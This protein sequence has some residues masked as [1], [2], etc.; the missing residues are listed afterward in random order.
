MI[1][2]KKQRFVVFELVQSPDLSPAVEDIF[3]AKPDPGPS[4]EVDP[5]EFFDFFHDEPG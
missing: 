5:G 1:R 2:G 3:I 4:E